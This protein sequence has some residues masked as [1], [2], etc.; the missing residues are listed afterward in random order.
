MLRLLLH[1]T[2]GT[3]LLMCYIYLDL[4]LVMFTGQYTTA[5]VQVYSVVLLAE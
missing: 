3:H 1:N 2:V 5:P 4:L